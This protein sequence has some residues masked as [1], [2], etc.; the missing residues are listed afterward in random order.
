MTS[1][2]QMLPGNLFGDADKVFEQM[3]TSAGPVAIRLL[4]A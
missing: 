3:L 2:A 4:I 1:V